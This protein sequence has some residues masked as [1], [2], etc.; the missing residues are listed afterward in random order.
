ML[1][2][3]LCVCFL[4]H[5]LRK[6]DRVVASKIEKKKRPIDAEESQKKKGGGGVK[7]DKRRPNS[8]SER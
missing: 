3:S 7:L 2:S 6:P 5:D 4:G 1:L 8:H